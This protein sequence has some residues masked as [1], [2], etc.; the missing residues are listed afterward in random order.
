MRKHRLNLD[1]DEETFES[2]NEL[3][4]KSGLKTKTRLMRKALVLFAFYVDIE[5]EGGK[6]YTK[7]IDGQEDRVKLL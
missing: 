3:V 5:K 2:L 6:F 7:S 1:L 4:R